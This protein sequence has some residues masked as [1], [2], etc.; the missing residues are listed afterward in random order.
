MV[1]NRTASLP[2]KIRIA[3]VIDSLRRHGTQKSLV[4]I[5]SG[6]AERGY[7]QRVYVLN[8]VV[9]ADIVQSLTSVGARVTVVGK[10][11]LVA[12]VG[13]LR[14][15]ADF[16]SW[17]PLIVQTFLPFGDVIGRTLARMANV[18]IIVSS[19]RNRNLGKRSWQ[20][21][22]DRMTIRWADRVIF[23]SKHVVPFSMAR[24]GVHPK[25]VAHVPNG[26]EIYGLRPSSGTARIR[27]ELGIGTTTR[28]IGTVGRLY[29]HKGHR[30]LL[31]AFAQ[32]L[33]DGADAVLLMIGEGPLRADLE[34]QAMQLGV[35]GKT[36]FL[37]ERADIPDLLACM[38]IY[39]HASLWE[40]MPN[41][42]MEAMAAGKPVVATGVDGTT[43]LITDGE[44]G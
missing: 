34:A 1:K 3:Y 43:E 14:L 27:C 29:P 15:V 39:V 13:L 20:L 31:S 10:A 2:A 19:I 26:V 35:A 22:L 9:V 7:E 6:L 21:L 11:Q 8:D 30:H 40:G 42:V 28:V 44:T 4:S 32:V 24:E 23:N 25:Q 36:R 38:D 16:R 5:V 37:G 17:Q 33:A 41:A 12:L 18:P